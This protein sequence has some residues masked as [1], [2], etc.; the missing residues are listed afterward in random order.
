VLA[1]RPNGTRRI[2]CLQF[3]T[4][5][6]PDAFVSDRNE[7][8]IH[9]PSGYLYLRNDVK[10]VPRFMGR[11]QMETVDKDLSAVD[12]ACRTDDDWSRRASL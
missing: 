9:A 11:Q 8:V 12:Q 4:D 6:I 3:N 10:F 2:E 1:F 7:K 5:E